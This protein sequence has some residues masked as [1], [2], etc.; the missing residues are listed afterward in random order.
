[1]RDFRGAYLVA[2]RIRTFMLPRG[3]THRRDHLVS[4]MHV[5]YGTDVLVLFPL[6]QDNSLRD[7]III[8]TVPHRIPAAPQCI[9]SE[10]FPNKCTVEQQTLARER[11]IFTH[12]PRTGHAKFYRR[13]QPVTMLRIDAIEVDHDMWSG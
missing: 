12:M 8:R 1:M 3:T 7:K 4:A 10:I 6:E 2:P 5:M 9:C 11:L 13:R